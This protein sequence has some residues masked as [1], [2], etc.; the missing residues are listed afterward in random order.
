MPNGLRTI[1]YHQGYPKFCDIANLAI[2]Q[3]SATSVKFTLVMGNNQGTWKK[4]HS[5]KISQIFVT[6]WQNLLRKKPLIAT[7]LVVNLPPEHIR[8]VETLSHKN[9][10]KHNKSQLQWSHQKVG[11]QKEI[12]GNWTPTIH[13]MPHVALVEGSLIMNLTNFLLH[14]QKGK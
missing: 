8:C 4:Q 11:N 14:V 2:S 10:G 6:K 9:S 5:P 3:K 12:W 7:S 1:G 13:R